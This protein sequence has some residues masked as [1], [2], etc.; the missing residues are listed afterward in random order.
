MVVQKDMG[1]F[2]GWGLLMVAL[3]DIP[4][5]MKNV[6]LWDRLLVHLKMLM[7]VSDLEKMKI[8][9]MDIEMVVE[10]KVELKGFL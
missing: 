8:F 10:L 9:L 5:D 1:K 4:K 2:V 7:K 3:M 6:A